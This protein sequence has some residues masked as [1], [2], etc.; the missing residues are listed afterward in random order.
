MKIVRYSLGVEALSYMR[1]ALEPASRTLFPYL[2]D[3]LN[4]QAG[5]VYTFAPEGLS[6]D[7]LHTF[8]ASIAPKRDMGA[9]GCDGTGLLLRSASVDDSALQEAASREVQAFLTCHSKHVAVFAEQLHSARHL[10]HLQKHDVRLMVLNE[11]VYFFLT[12]E[13]AD[14]SRIQN[15]LSVANVPT[16]PLVG[17]L[18]LASDRLLQRC[19]GTRLVELQEDDVH[20]IVSGVKVVVIGAYDGEGFLFWRIIG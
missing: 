14:L 13:D 4:L 15:T 12:G 19:W 10:S 9:F 3:L 1:W 11:E 20:E 8:R 6:H 5:M 2:L 16:P 17:V 18:F 7:I